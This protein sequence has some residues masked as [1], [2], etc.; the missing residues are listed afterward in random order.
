MN[1]DILVRELRAIV[2]DAY[3][4]VEKED[5][6]VYEQDGSIMQVLP[7]VVALPG[8]TEQVAGVVRA[9][10]RANVPI[11]PRGSGTG[12]AGGAVPAEGGV[13]ISLAR[14]NR[15][16][17]LDLRDRIAVVEPG[18]INQDVT[19][20]VAAG[21]V[22]FAPDPSSQAACSI[23]GNIAKNSGG[24]HTPGPGGPTNHV[25]GVGGGLGDGP[26]VW[27]GGGGAGPPRYDLGGA[28]CGSAGAGG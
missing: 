28:A 17:E 21:G 7:E 24:P 5:V 3:V 27:G 16:L 4:L 25:V 14:M 9:A 22:F 1:R 8:S 18:V 19:K 13:V 23:G 20:A 26:G 11:V 12:L 10:R 15:I 2:G 6:I